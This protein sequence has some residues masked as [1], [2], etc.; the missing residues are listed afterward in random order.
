M[1]IHTDPCTLHTKPGRSK[2]R[3]IEGQSGRTSGS[4]LGYPIYLVFAP[5]KPVSVSPLPS[6]TR[7]VS[8]HL[9]SQPRVCYSSHSFVIRDHRSASKP[10]QLQ[11][12][13]PALQ[14]SLS[15]LYI[16]RAL[17]APIRIAF[18]RADLHQLSVPARALSHSLS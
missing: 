5:C 13:E 18:A 2:L 11:L 8:L 4:T 15:P 10:I 3:A 1:Y 6:F 9:H 12:S 16:S 17:V 14:L 7:L